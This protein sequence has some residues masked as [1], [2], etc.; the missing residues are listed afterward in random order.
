MFTGI[1]ESTGL[2]ASLKITPGGGHLTLAGV[3]FADD[4]VLGESVAVNGCC[5][6]VVASGKRE[7]SF[8][9]LQE[10]LRLTNLGDLS[11]GDAV[12]L[13]RAMRAGDRLSGH[14]VQGHIDASALILEYAPAGQDHRYTVALPEAGRRLLIPKG[15]ITVNGISLTV[16]SLEE[17]RFTLWIT[18]HT[19]AVTTLRYAMVGQKVNLEYDFLGKQVDRILALRGH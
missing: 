13:E 15:S 2:V 9:L 1:I 14:F 6:T 3:A 19:H 17:D 18:P 5:L 4:L 12:N 8:D 7:V 10:T 16:A 11:V